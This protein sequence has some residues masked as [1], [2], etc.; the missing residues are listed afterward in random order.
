M[1]AR[2]VHVEELTTENTQV[3]GFNG[4][5]TVNCGFSLPIVWHQPTGLYSALSVTRTP[6]PVWS[7]EEKIQELA[8]TADRLEGPLDSLVWSTEEEIQELAASGRL[9]L[10]LGTKKLELASFPDGV[11]SSPAPILLPVE[12][13]LEWNLVPL[14][15]P[16]VVWAKDVFLFH[17]SKTEKDLW[18]DTFAGFPPWYRGVP[19][20]AESTGPSLF[21]EFYVA[22]AD[23]EKTEYCLDRWGD[24]ARG[25]LRQLRIE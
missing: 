16:V 21:E 6:G 2:T 1:G 8:L 14:K 19:S 25:F 3:R 15:Q 23:I 7:T 17:L 9:T 5:A 4:R 13:N 10:L 12:W 18:R 22:C 20:H 11:K 24:L